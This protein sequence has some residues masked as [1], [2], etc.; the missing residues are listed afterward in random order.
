MRNTK[1]KSVSMNSEDVVIIETPNGIGKIIANYESRGYQTK[2]ERKL[3]FYIL[4]P[5]SK[6]LKGITNDV[7]RGQLIE[8]WQKSGYSFQY[9]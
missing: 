6:Q 7:R 1:F 9:P 2:Y 4:A 5:G 8:H 3:F